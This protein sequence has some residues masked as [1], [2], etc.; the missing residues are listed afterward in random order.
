[1]SKLK[2]FDK[3]FLT[4]MMKRK[5]FKYKS[6]YHLAIITSLLLFLTSSFNILQLFHDFSL[7]KLI[8]VC[9]SIIFSSFAFI[10]LVEK[11]D[12]AVLFLNLSLV[13]YMILIGFYSLV[14]FLNMETQAFENI[15]F[16][17]LL[18][19]TFILIIVNLYKIKPFTGAEEIENIGQT[20]E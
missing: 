7:L 16:K 14:G 18:V 2:I 1:M 19:L 6:V 13:F 10:N 12:K 17:L 3:V 20:K 5:I 4:Q 9:C 11:Y 15:Y 8:L